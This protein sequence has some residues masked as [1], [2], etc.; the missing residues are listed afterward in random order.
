[1][2]NLFYKP[3]DAWV[4]DCIPYYEN[5]IYYIYY[6]HDERVKPNEYGEETTWHLV[7]TTDF[8]NFE[9][10]GEAILRGGPDEFNWNIYTGSICKDK[11]GLYHAFYTGYNADLMVNGKKAQV[12]MQAVSEDLLH[13][14]TV[15]DFLFTS[16]EKQYEIFDWRDPFVF[17]NDKDEC[18]WMLLAARING[19]GEHRG[20]C[21]ALCKSKDLMNWS[22]EEPFYAPNMYITMEC[23]EIFQIGD[24]WYLVFSTFSDRFV[25]HYRMSRSLSGPWII[26]ENDD[27]DTRACYAIKTA[28]DGVERYG[29][30]WIASKEGSTDFGPWEWGGTLAIHKIEQDINTGLLSVQ[31]P[32]AVRKYF[33]QKQKISEFINVN[34]CVLKNTQGIQLH[35][36]TLGA[37]L[38]Q[39]P[40]TDFSL[41]MTLCPQDNV[42]EFGVALHTDDGLEKGYF[43]RF[44]TMHNRV[45]LDMWPRAEKGRFQWQINGDIPYQIELERTLCTTQVYKL[46]ILREGTICVIYINDCVALSTRMY[47]HREGLI[48]AYVIQGDL[49]IEETT[50]LI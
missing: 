12:V 49:N 31:P 7:T 44:D 24:W 40:S 25:T 23:P 37:A 1:M 22:Y 32:E 48:G 46:Q 10:K 14:E 6:L 35:S 42:T 38:T 26:P 34:S 20:G 18:Y 28:S 29:F 8:V 3:K 21:T 13:W 27:F 16:D 50:I 17:W 11:E 43:L 33:T 2:T 36:D 19:A 9:S 41:S 47:N 5:G 45:V 30:G 39:A 15:K 4:G